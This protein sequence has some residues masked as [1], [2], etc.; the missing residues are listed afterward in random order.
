VLSAWFCLKHQPNAFSH[1]GFFFFDFIESLLCGPITEAESE[2]FCTILFSLPQEK[3]TE[4]NGFKIRT[5]EIFPMEQLTSGLRICDS[6]KK[7]LTRDFVITMH[8]DQIK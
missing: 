7:K 8:C 5:Q 3:L 1:H 6:C 2:A 4:T